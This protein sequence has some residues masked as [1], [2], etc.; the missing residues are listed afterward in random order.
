MRIYIANLAQYNAG[1]LVG[2][3]IDVP[4]DVEDLQAEITRIVG[5]DEWAIH[6]YEGYNG[7]G[8]HPDLA[9]VVAI[10]DALEEYPQAVVEWAETATNDD[11]L[12]SFIEERWQGTFRDVEAWAI[13]YIDSAYDVEK[14]LGD[15]SYYFDYAAFGRDAEMSGDIVTIDTPDGLAVLSNT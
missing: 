13:D 15:L 14:M 2:E 6:D 4:S 8:E 11:D 7:L 5:S 1:K 12:K 10:A 9:K 3:W